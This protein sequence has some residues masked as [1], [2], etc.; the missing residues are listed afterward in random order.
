MRRF[1]LML[2]KWNKLDN[3][4]KIFPAA[5]TKKE[6]Q[7]F[8]LSCEL[9]EDINPKI[10]EEAL[11]ET[12]K[13]FPVYQYV[14]KR[15]LF[16]Y[17]LEKTKK[18]PVLKEEN[19]PICSE[20]YDKNSKNLLYEVSYFGKRINFEIYHALSD[21]TGAMNFLR[22]ITA[23]YLSIKNGIPEPLIDYDASFS[24]MENDSF[25]KYYSSK[26]S[27]KPMKNKKAC[28]L[29]GSKYPEGRIKIIRGHLDLKAALE[30]AHKYNV[31]LTV[32]LVSCLADAINLELSLRAK[33]RPVRLVIPVNLRKYYKSESARNFF[34]IVFTEYDFNDKN[35]DFEKILQ[36][37]CETFKNELS[38]EKISI[39]LN[40]L[41]SYEHNLLARA[42]P[43]YFKDILLKIAYLK[44]EGESTATLSNIGMVKMPDSL[45]SYIKSFDFCSGT[46]KMQANVCSFGNCLSISFTTA[47]ISSDIQKNFFRKLAS[48]GIDVEISA[49]RTDE[50]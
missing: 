9:F 22:T 41:L 12:I 14:L 11:Y 28:K 50:E 45:C 32:L 48:F 1:T 18:R 30:V 46:G 25:N 2:N 20:I 29:T 4:A 43:L 23:K 42:V 27:E 16:W 34:S 13:N 49:N 33:R 26:S 24:Q 38:P 15:G 17:Y 7:V 10:L 3:A 44:N 39:R 35:M 19:K 31:S 21:G 8:R 37:T 40:S 6:T 47:F 36:T 5:S